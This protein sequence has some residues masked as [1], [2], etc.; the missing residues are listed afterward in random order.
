MRLKKWLRFSLATIIVVS[1]IALALIY[2]HERSVTVVDKKYKY[3]KWPDPR[4][5]PV[6]VPLVNINFDHRS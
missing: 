6:K 2:F 5:A 4:D 1:L 3:E